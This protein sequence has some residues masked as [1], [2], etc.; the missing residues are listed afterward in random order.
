MI[1]ELTRATIVQPGRILSVTIRIYLFSVEYTWTGLTI[2]SSIWRMTVTLN[3]IAFHGLSHLLVKVYICRRSIAPINW[4]CEE[5]LLQPQ[6]SSKPSLSS[7]IYFLRNTKWP[8]CDHSFPLSLSLLIQLG[9]FIM[10]PS[11]NLNLANCQLNWNRFVVF[12]FM[13]RIHIVAHWQITQHCAD[14]IENST[15]PEDTG[16]WTPQTGKDYLDRPL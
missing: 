13:A 8:E 5:E 6:S 11:V 2:S 3:I 12:I 14:K 9:R 10:V 7:P 15:T 16:K 1:A 4:I